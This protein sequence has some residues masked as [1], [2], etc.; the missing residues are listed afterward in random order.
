MLVGD[1]RERETGRVFIIFF[2]FQVR[3]ELGLEPWGRRE[4]GGGSMSDELKL[5]IAD[6]D[7]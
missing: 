4:M 5:L 7:T 3:G 2:S 6:S 1:P